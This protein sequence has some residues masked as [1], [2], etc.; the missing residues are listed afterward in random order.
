MCGYSSDALR[1]NSHG[2]G[3]LEQESWK[4]ERKDMVSKTFD[5]G[6]LPHE[7]DR[8]E[9]TSDPET[10]NKCTPHKRSPHKKAS[11]TAPEKGRF[12][13]HFCMHLDSCMP[14]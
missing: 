8:I 11:G 9:S 3:S 12:V 4:P 14:T 6:V 1:G 7:R 2:E 5:A 13:G 10:T